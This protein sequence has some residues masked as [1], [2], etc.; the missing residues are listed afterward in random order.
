MRRA[1]VAVVAT[2]VAAVVA[3]LGLVI[4]APAFAAVSASDEPMPIVETTATAGAML[5]YVSVP[6]DEQRGR[7]VVATILGTAA[8]A[9]PSPTAAVSSING[10]VAADGRIHL[11]VQLPTDA[12]PG[13]S[14]TLAVRAGDF[15]DS[16]TVT[17]AA[18]VPID[19]KSTKTADVAVDDAFD[20]T[21]IIWFGAGVLVFLAALI[22]VT[23][24]SRRAQ[25]PRR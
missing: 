20:R 1:L 8:V 10:R 2:A 16:R 7:T 25:R 13:S 3:A 5:D 23:Q 9:N 6:T 12:M 24:F 4:P 15:T 17:I 19:V 21:P 22:A 14:Y 11:E 18:A